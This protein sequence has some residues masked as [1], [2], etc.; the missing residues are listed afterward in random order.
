MKCNSVSQDMVRLWLKGLGEQ[1]PLILHVLLF[2]M[3]TPTAVVS[4]FKNLL[5]EGGKRL[6]PSSAR[7]C[8]DCS[9]LQVTEI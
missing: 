7:S 9:Q 8:W 6:G 1:F 4:I 3:V 2:L 5:R